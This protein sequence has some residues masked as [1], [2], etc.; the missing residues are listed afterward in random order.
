MPRFHVAVRPMNIARQRHVASIRRHAKPNR[1]HRHG[2]PQITDVQRTQLGSTWPLNGRGDASVNAGGRRRVWGEQSHRSHSCGRQP[3]CASSERVSSDA[4][5]WICC[6]VRGTGFRAADRRGRSRGWSA[7]LVSQHGVPTAIRWY[8]RSVAGRS[9]EAAES[10][11]V[12]VT[13]SIVCARGLRSNRRPCNMSRSQRCT[14]AALERASELFKKKNR[15]VFFRQR[16]TPA[17]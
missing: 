11:G 14:P 6:C 4:Q 15:I 17:A 3:P 16:I 13:F 8:L 10:E 1:S 7:A 5:N 9:R 2:S 12:G